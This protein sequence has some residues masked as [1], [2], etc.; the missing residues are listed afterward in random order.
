[1][2]AED[3]IAQGINLEYVIDAYRDLTSQGKQFLL[4]TGDRNFFNLLMG[5]KEIYQMIADGKSAQQIKATWADDVARFKAQ[6][7]P[8]LLYAE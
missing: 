8:Y 6:R 1:M 4:R 7:K 2:D 5:D 3:A